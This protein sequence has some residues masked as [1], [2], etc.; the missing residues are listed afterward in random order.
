MLKINEIISGSLLTI[1]TDC[2]I[3]NQTTFDLAPHCN[4]PATNGNDLVTL[5]YVESLVGQYSGGYNFFFN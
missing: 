3:N 5:G 2:L 4:T 1:N